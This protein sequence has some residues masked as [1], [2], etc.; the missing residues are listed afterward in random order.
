M[1]AHSFRASLEI[2]QK[3]EAVLDKWFESRF[4]YAIEPS[5]QPQQRVGIDRWFTHDKFDEGKR[6]SVEYKAD[7]RAFKTRN[8]F[9]ETIAYDSNGGKLG[10]GLSCSADFLAYYIPGLSTV[11]IFQPDTIRGLIP[12]WARRHRLRVSNNGSY[13]GHGILVPLKV[14]EAASA[15]RYSGVGA[16]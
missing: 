3:Y 16:G 13:N 14:F 15:S 2:G 12:A 8:V 9:V 10:W 4:G 5:T 1:K 7:I 11:W 6:V